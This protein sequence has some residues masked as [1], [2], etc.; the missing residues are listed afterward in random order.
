MQEKF[1]TQ[2]KGCLQ[3]ESM[4]AS[5]LKSFFLHLQAESFSMSF[6]LMYVLLFDHPLPPHLSIHNLSCGSVIYLCVESLY[7]Y[8]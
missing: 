3:F 7:P 1:T 5:I 4:F 8:V 2:I 6:V